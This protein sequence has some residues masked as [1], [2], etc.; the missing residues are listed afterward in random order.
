MSS[1]NILGIY[2]GGASQF[3]RGGGTKAPL[4]PL[5]HACAC[6]VHVVR[7]IW[8]YY[9]YTEEAGYTAGSERTRIVE[10]NTEKW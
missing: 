8:G 7:F 2:Q 9:I 10:E 5:K 3:S 6:N 4:A 1:A